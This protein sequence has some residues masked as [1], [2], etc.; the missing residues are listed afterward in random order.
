MLTT[1]TKSLCPIR[2]VHVGHVLAAARSAPYSMI[3]GVSAA[4][5]ADLI[6]RYQS[7]GSAWAMVVDDRAIALGGV[8]RLWDG[9]G[10]AWL[11]STP[12][13]EQYRFTFARITRI[14]IDEAILAMGLHRV[15]MAVCHQHRR[16]IRFA[17]WLGL[18]PEGIMRAYSADRCDYVRLARTITGGD[19]G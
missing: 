3:R 16:A 9:V 15:Q 7:A 1:S 18:A 17:R 10:E 11:M 19:D 5:F 13:I 2:P 8:Y 12:A 4:G 14:V 6:R